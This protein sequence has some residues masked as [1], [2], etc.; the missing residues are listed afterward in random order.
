MCAD[1][2]VANDSQKNRHPTLRA[3]CCCTPVFP[4][5]HMQQLLLVKRLKQ[6][7]RCQQLKCD[8]KCYAL[9]S[10]ITWSMSPGAKMSRPS[11]NRIWY[12]AH[13]FGGQLGSRYHSCAT[14]P[15]AQPVT[16]SGPIRHSTFCP[17]SNRT[18]GRSVS[19]S[20]SSSSYGGHSASSPFDHF[21]STSSV[22]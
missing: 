2:G 5:H 18:L 19:S 12:G 10:L 16:G 8:A 4:L 17:I 20:Y 13:E 6:V 22:G 1:F 14:V 3:P 7:G 15:G 9:A 21:V 11:S